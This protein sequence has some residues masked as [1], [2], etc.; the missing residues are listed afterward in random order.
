MSKDRNPNR[1]YKVRPLKPEREI[2]FAHAWCRLPLATV[3]RHLRDINSSLLG[4]R[5]EVYNH[6]FRRLGVP[7]SRTVYAAALPDTSTIIWLPESCTEFLS[8]LSTRAQDPVSFISVYEPMR[9]RS[10]LAF[11]N[12]EVA[13]E[14]YDP[15]EQ[16]RSN[17]WS[18]K[19]LSGLGPRRFPTLDE[20]LAH[21]KPWFEPK[22]WLWSSERWQNEGFRDE[23]LARPTCEHRWAVQFTYNRGPIQCIGDAPVDTVQWT[24]AENVRDAS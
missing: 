2:A 17:V 15:E 16:I 14:V 7:F 21:V 4:R 13:V 8:E 20:F 3:V 9:A 5:R 19:E 18:G 12:G 23:L 22:D 10:F 1:K 11:E 6:I 24:M